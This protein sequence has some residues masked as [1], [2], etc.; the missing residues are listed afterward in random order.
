M[1]VLGEAL[2]RVASGR[3]AVVLIEGEAGIGKTRLLDEALREAR[4]R[5]MQVAAGR[6]EELERTRPFGLVAD[7]FGCVRSSPDARRTAIAEMLARGG[8]D[9]GPIT[10][11]SDPG[12]RFQVI[13]AFADL[14]EEVALSGP[15]VIGADDLQW[16]D[17]SSLVTLAAL[18]RRLAYFPAALIGCLRLWPR[19]PELDRLAGALTSAGAR[20][21]TLHGLADDAVS[22]LVAEMVAAVPGQ[23]LL[24]R[25]AGAAGNPL[26]VTELL[27]A[28]AQEGTIDTAGGLAEAADV[29]LPPTLR[30]TILR[31]ISFL[32]EDT[33]LALRA[34]T[35]LGSGFSLTD[36]ATV[37]A[38]PSLDLSVALEKA[39]R[40]NVLEDDGVR[41]RFRHDL[42]RSSIYQDLPAS[43]RQGLHREAGLRLA[44][45]G[46]PALQVAE[47]LARGATNGDAETIKW[48]TQG[49]REAAG[50]S[51]DVAVDLLARA[52]RL[53]PATDPD[54]DR[55]L[56]EQA[57]SL[58][59]SGRIAE[60]EI[61][62][63]DLLDRAH[64]QAVQGTVRICLGHALLAQGQAGDAL[65]ELELAAECSALPSNDRAAASAW[66]SYARLALGDLD[67][68]SAVAE[69]ARSMAESAGDR[70]SA[71]IAMA[72]LALVSEFHGNLRDSLRIIDEAVRLADE[73]PGR[74]GHRYPLHAIR[75][76]LLIECDQLDEAR[77]SIGAGRRICEEL[78][79]RW[80]LP[81]YQVFGAY[82]RF[83]AGEWDDAI[84][85]L[86]A[87]FELAEEIGETYSRVYAHG[88]LSLIR[89]HRNELSGA[90]DAAEA[91][92][93]DLAGRAP[94]YRMTLAAWPS[95]LISEANGQPARAL[96]IMS[97]AWDTCL[98]S[99][100]AL[101]YPAVGPDLVRL[102][103]TLGYPER[104]RAVSAAV[105]EVAS[106]NEVPWITGSA[107]RC[108][109]LIED[110][111]EILEAAAAAYARGSRL[112]QGA[113]ACEDAGAAYSRHGHLDRA[114]PLLDQ[115]ISIYERLGA[116]RDLAR[117]EAILREAGIRRGRRGRRDRP[118]VGWRSLTPA[119]QAIA[120]L[121]AQGL[122]NPQI[123][124]RLYVSRRTVQTHLAH[125]FAKLDINSRAQLAAA[126]TQHGV[127]QPLG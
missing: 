80:P 117:S 64:D 95:A 82:G 97:T 9:Q 61:A 72:S 30:L 88:V 111:A 46:A 113:F 77:A 39:I 91:A 41:L 118:Q 65:R 16:A 74:L 52:V 6:A 12:L 31:R 40:A 69:K 109:G 47:H 79:V 68:A 102:M 103:L 121:V 73:S 54:R 101:E 35:V 85:E 7:A 44:Q 84:A 56:A 14:A 45:A 36:L 28:L 5:G 33:L 38:R 48:L 11:T 57:S 124:D 24:A 89:F 21:L 83:V 116:K 3:A 96:A 110:D 98:S 122:S 13:D 4:D 53:M 25:M 81:S 71:S 86:E 126:V 26:F 99:G 20:L 67:G 92:E 2:D 78:G 42:I 120:T 15:L 43:M 115:A 49:A 10:V 63:K 32:S 58:M 87:G 62:C 106:G 59:L 66:A 119:E 100:M 27:A 107:L 34:A 23:R 90:R 93:R 19:R 50:H 108:Q 112:L 22:D 75:G 29:A 70:L 123:G 51:P 8:G 105:S 1:A 17:P 60:A 76:W 94:G 55:M 125:M 104:A 114:R 18:S 127:S 37:T